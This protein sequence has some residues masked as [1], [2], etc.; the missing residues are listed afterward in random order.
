MAKQKRTAYGIAEDGV[1]IKLAYL[2]R[3]GQ[4]ISLQALEQVELEQSLYQHLPAQPAEAQPEAWK[5]ENGSSGELQV[6][7]ISLDTISS[8]RTQPYEKLFQTYSLNQGLLAINAFEEQFIKLPIGS[9]PTAK[10]KQKLVRENIPAAEFKEKHWQTSVVSINEQPELWVHHGNNRLLEILEAAQKSQKTRFYFKL[11]DA[12]ETALANLYMHTSTAAE[13]EKNMVLYLGRDFRR[14]LLFEGRKWTF[15]LP[16]SITQQQPDIDIVYSKLSLALDEAHLADP[17]NLYVCGDNCFLDSVEYLRTQLPNTNVEMWHL[18]NLYLDGDAAQLYEADM[19]ARF[20]LPIALAWKALTMEEAGVVKS[21]FLPGYIRESQKS[22]KLAWHGYLLFA[23]LFLATLFLAFTY[24]NLKNSII[25][26][27]TL[28]KTL[29]R[30]YTVKKQ[31]AESMLAMQR[32]IEQQNKNLEII[33]TLLTDKNP[34]TE[35]VTRLNNS[36]QTH[37]TSWITNLRKEGEGIK[38]TGVTTYRPNIVYFASVFPNGSIINAKHREIRSFTVWDFE[39]NYSYPE[40]DWY[41]MMETD[42]ENLRRYQEEQRELQLKKD[43][44][45]QGKPTAAAGKSQD[46]QVSAIGSAID[47]PYP[48]KKL[49]EN[50]NDPAVKAYKDIVTAFNARNNWLMVD[51]GVK[52]INN[53][54]RN[55]LT[56]YVRWY[57]AYRAVQNKENDKALIW[58]EPMLSNKRDAVYPYTALLAGMIYKNHGNKQ[59]A[60]NYWRSITQ[61]Y[62]QHPTART[63]RKLIDAQ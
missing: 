32:A 7:D 6:E 28:N 36:F 18:N 1:S 5:P 51:L 41:K 21:N 52:Y 49:L 2:T 3:D 54:P 62:P 38:V 16:I 48:D 30:E 4:Q 17:Q 29:T 61:D 37:P 34:W 12:N 59:A 31:Q 45:A 26:E 20:A 47:I 35:I 63:A 23:L 10:Q 39:I 50:T 8:F 13:G 57:L 33:K 22:F 44:D 42:A 9:E 24:A 25:R 56:S 60:D 40:V 19:I 46:E 53:Y 14:A 58:I 27:N 11:A 15:S 43:L 55:T